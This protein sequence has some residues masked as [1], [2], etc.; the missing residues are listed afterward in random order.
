MSYSFPDYLVRTRID[1]QP[2]SFEW[3]DSKYPEKQYDSGWI[4]NALATTTLRARIV[5]GLGA[6][7][8][9]VFR[10][11]NFSKDSAPIQIAEACWAA[12]IHRRYLSYWEFPRSEWVG[13]VKGPLWCAMTW[14]QPMVLTGDNN[15]W[16]C[17][18]G[19][20]YLSRLAMHVLPEPERFENWLKEVI[21]RVVHFYSAPPEDPLEDLFSEREEQR[22]GPLIAREVLD[23]AFEYKPDAAERLTK[24]YLSGLGKQK[25]PYLCLPQKK[26]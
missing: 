8:W 2:V 22:R 24:T 19:L 7:E 26:R 3:D 25:N 11:R 12:T 15:P 5:V 20:S 9:I 10:F 16:D 17:E 13:N 18:E 4:I 6:Y 21:K 14:V 1:Q 23:P